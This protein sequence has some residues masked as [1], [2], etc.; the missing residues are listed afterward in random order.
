MKNH[1]ERYTRPNAGIKCIHGRSIV[2]DVIALAVVV[3]LLGGC[4]TAERT[5]STT[6]PAYASLPNGRDPRNPDQ[7]SDLGKQFHR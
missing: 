1:G 4:S 5:L 2:T 6:V 7:Y 3:S